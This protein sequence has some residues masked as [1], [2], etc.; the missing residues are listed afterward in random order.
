MR[1]LLFFDLPTITTEHQK[2]YRGFVKSLKKEGFYMLQESVYVK[3]A[4]NNQ[5][6]EGTL[7]RV[8]GIMPKEGSIMTLTITEKQF[9]SMNVFIGEKNSD[10]INTIDRVVKL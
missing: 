4:I 10:I 6:A 7:N 8:K 3:M 5:I 2:A 1:I 9:A